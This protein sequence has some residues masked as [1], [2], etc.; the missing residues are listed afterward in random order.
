MLKSAN[1]Q[2]G[3]FQ[4]VMPCLP[5]RRHSPGLECWRQPD[6]A[7]GNKSVGRTDHS[8]ATTPEVFTHAPNDM[9]PGWI[10]DVLALMSLLN[11]RLWG[12]S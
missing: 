7:S 5:E 2:I 6:I 9:Y 11:I 3:L 10:N 4:E 12:L 1:T 8:D